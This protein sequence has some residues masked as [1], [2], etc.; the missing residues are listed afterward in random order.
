MPP[1]A[2]GGGGSKGG[3]GGLS[4]AD[5][6]LLEAAKKKQSK[7][8]ADR[9]AAKIAKK[10]L[11]LQ[12]K[13]KTFDFS[14]IGDGMPESLASLM[15]VKK[16]SKKR[17][18]KKHESSSS[19]FDSDSSSS[20]DD[21]RDRLKKALEYVQNKAQE[22]KKLQ[23][24]VDTLQTVASEYDILKTE[25]AEKQKTDGAV[26]FT[27]EEWEALRNAAST[28]AIAASPRKDGLFASVMCARNSTTDSGISSKTGEIIGN[29]DK[30]LRQAS[31]IQSF[32][33]SLQVPTKTEALLRKVAEA[34]AKEH[35]SSPEDLEELHKLKD[36]WGINTQA[37]KHHT[38]LQ[39]LMRA[40]VARS[41]D[42][43]VRDLCLSS[44]T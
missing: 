41:I 23:E 38:I 37:Q 27:I 19:D 7:Q 30:R 5:R 3:G 4:H 21:T 32:E 25:I 39:A 44:S 29:L 10:L 8:S 11:Q 22:N 34:A 1:K 13:E 31:E 35:F 14:A 15:S 36:K 40:C 12:R 33:A 20:S 24:K 42:I 18:K 17:H 28:K 6:Q 9:Q 26:R 16:K 2:K 43:G